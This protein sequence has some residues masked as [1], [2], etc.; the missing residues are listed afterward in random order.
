[1]ILNEALAVG[2]RQTSPEPVVVDTSRAHRRLMPDNL[3]GDL[4]PLN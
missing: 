1:V 3:A 2:V 4:A